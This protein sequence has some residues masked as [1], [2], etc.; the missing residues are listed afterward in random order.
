[1]K[2][3]A[4]SA[5]VVL[6]FVIYAHHSKND[7]EIQSLQVGDSGTSSTSAQSNSSSTPPTNSS[8]AIRFKDGSYT[9][10]VT[11]AFYGNIQVKAVIQNGKIS[12]VQFLQYPND[13]G[14]SVTINSQA[15]PDLRTEA[16]QSQSA[17]VDTVSG[18][19]QT[20]EAFRESLQSALNQAQG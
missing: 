4:L 17:Q 16:I 7:E 11:D 6:L 12:D 15:M 1:M 10:S 9:G 2:K 8:S 20:S 18:A 3:V 13:R 5:F 19:T 14:E